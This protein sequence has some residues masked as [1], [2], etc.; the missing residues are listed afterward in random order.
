M[1]KL[2]ALAAV[3]LGAALPALAAPS[4]P[5]TK[6]VETEVTE[7]KDAVSNRAYSDRAIYE[8]AHALF[9]RVP[10]TSIAVDVHLRGWDK[11]KKIDSAPATV[12]R[13]MATAKDKLAFY[14]AEV[15]PVNLTQAVDYAERMKGAG[16]VDFDKEQEMKDNQMGVY[17]Y[18]KTQLGT[19][20]LNNV[21]SLIAAKIGDALAFATLAHEAGHARDHQNG[22]LDSKLVIEGEI[23][24]F[25]TQYL[26]LKI[27]DPYGERVAFLR[28]KMMNEQTARPSQLTDTTLAYLSH[29]AKL[30]DTGGDEKKL[31]DFVD[32]MGYKDGHH[33]DEGHPGPVKS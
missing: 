28:A 31:K 29:L 32:E 15:P 12:D 24:A 1:R 13:I 30:Q 6:Q 27:A 16:K 2:P 7:L 5:S 21:L 8:Q 3:L 19:I 26:W 11:E 18:V 22:R 9:G 20:R 25:K 33:H 14:S 4:A 17:A 10:S 23:L